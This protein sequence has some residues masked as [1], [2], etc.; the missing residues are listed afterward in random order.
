[1]KDQ[2]GTNHELSEENAFLKQKIRELKHSEA[3]IA[4]FMENIYA[5]FRHRR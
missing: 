4:F 2:S 5:I 1:M 3:D